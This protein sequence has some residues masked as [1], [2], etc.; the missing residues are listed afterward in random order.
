MKNQQKE[1][2]KTDL[3][4][5]KFLKKSEEEILEIDNKIKTTNQLE[6]K[7]LLT[8]TK[9]LKE[10]EIIKYKNL[11]KDKEI[12]IVNIKQLEEKLVQPDLINTTKTALENQKI[13]AQ[14][15]IKNINEQITKKTNTINL[16]TN[17]NAIEKELQ[18]PQISSEL[19]QYLIKY[20]ENTE[21]KITNLEQQ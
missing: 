17:L 3:L 19:K 9:L 21:T 8:E 20:K 7:H 2:L 15:K 6:E 1:E 11:L 16:Q 5:K 14:N 4:L 12:N 18:D 10:K 13:Q